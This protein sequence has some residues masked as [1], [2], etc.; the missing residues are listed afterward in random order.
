VP[1]TCLAL[2]SHIQLPAIYAEVRPEL[3]SPQWMYKVVATS[4]SLCLVL[5]VRKKKKK[6]RKN[7]TLKSDNKWSAA[8]AAAAE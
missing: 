4:V 5:Y 8:A 2:Q 1:I 7:A 3:R 6:K